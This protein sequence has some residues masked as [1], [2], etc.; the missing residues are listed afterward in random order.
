MTQTAVRQYRTKHREWR[1]EAPGLNR[2]QVK[3]LMVV[4]R[5]LMTRCLNP[6][7]THFADYGGRGI[8]VCREWVE[9]TRAFVDWAI[10]S[11]YRPGLE[12]DRIDGDGAYCPD[13]CRWVTHHQNMWNRRK[14]AANAASK[15]KGVYRAVSG[16]ENHW[17]SSITVGG[18][19]MHLGRFSDEESAAR[20]YDLAARIHFGEFARLNFPQ[21]AP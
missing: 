10:R 9:S 19:R 2:E 13:N 1:L 6:N 20:A 17:A 11:G 14:P 21:E 8:T 15:F 7:S 16:R 5:G 4:R 3:R 12:I 18:S